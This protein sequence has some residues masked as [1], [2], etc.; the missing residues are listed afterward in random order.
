LNAVSQ[1]IE[2]IRSVFLDTQLFFAN[3]P[4]S[5]ALISYLENTEPAFR[6]IAYESASMAIA[7]KD[8]ENNDRLDQWLHFANGPASKHKAQVYIGL[9]WAIAKLNLPFT[10]IVASIETALYHRVAD[11]CGY[12]DG[13]FRQRHA[14]QNMQQPVYLPLS[15]MPI[16]DQGLG[17]SLWYS[18][19]ADIDKI[20]NKIESFPAERHAGLWRGIGIAVAY[21]GGCNDDTLKMLL[22]YASANAVQLACGSALAARSRMQA[23]T[24]TEDTDRCTRLWY[25]LTETERNIFS[26]EDDGLAAAEKKYLNW[27]I[28]IE[29][30]LAKSFEKAVME[31]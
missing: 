17:R 6:S 1:K 5:A 8:L 2:R 29:D 10:A 9:G 3:N 21:V 13:S 16:Y 30:G 22:Q 24:M 20:K 27:I 7:L 18:C 31:D 25:S 12:Y 11:G 15:A 19:N 28:R 23:N 4:E 26:L 14:V